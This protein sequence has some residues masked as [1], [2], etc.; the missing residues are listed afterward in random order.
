MTH[1][2]PLDLNPKTDEKEGAVE[3]YVG[4]RS[5]KYRRT[6]WRSGGSLTCHPQVL[7]DVERPSPLGLVVLVL[8]PS[9]SSILTDSYGPYGYVSK[10]FGSRISVVLLAFLSNPERNGVPTSR[11]L[12]WIPCVSRPPKNRKV[13]ASIHLMDVY[14]V[15][16][17]K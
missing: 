12:N 5:C 10:E 15:Q 1:R 7:N 3:S 4:K 13:A 2:T 6:S 8:E 9:R 16:L 17:T 11:P 14:G